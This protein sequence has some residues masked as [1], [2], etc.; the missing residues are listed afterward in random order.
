MLQQGFFPCV[1]FF[2]KKDM[3]LYILEIWSKIKNNI[4]YCDMEILLINSGSLS[5]VPSCRDN[6]SA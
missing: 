4:C 3:I 1:I 2:K 5:S 6:P